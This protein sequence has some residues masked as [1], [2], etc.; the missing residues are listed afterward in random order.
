MN[1]ECLRMTLDRRLWELFLETIQTVAAI[2]NIDADD[3]LERVLT[4]TDAEQFLN[5]FFENGLKKAG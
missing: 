1:A 4:N 3:L 2:L 5:R